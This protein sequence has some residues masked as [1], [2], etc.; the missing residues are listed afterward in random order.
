MALL[1]FIL[2]L[3]WT[4]GALLNYLADVLPRKRCL[5]APFCLNC[6]TRF[7]IFNYLISPRLCPSC[8]SRRSSRTYVVEIL[9][10]GIT[11]WLWESSEYYRMPFWLAEIL[12]LYL[13]L[14]TV[15]DLEHRLILHQ[16]T[17]IGAGLGVLAGIWQHGW[18]S[19]LMGGV[20]GFGVVLLLYYLG[21]L[22]VKLISKWRKERINEEALGFGDVSLSGVLGLM[23]GFPKIIL[24]L[25]ISILLGGI[26]SFLYLMVS[27]L[28]HRYRSF[29]AIPYAP[30]LI[31]GGI[32]IL[33][34]F[35]Y[36]IGMI[37]R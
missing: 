27:L 29:E 37:I 36:I 25:V 9:F 3:G 31:F 33:F 21:Y 26:V 5:V 30:F 6:Q 13:G 17:F 34:F 14:V 24:S 32:A 8:G 19:T 4:F 1:F 10:V 18:V 35:D 12:L 2:V 20:V 22:L 7:S 28:T 15:I 11:F 16:T 23:V